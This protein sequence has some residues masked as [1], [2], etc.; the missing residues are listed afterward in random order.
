MLWLC[1]L[2][3]A[4]IAGLGGKGDLTFACHS[5]QRH[6]QV[7]NLPDCAGFMECIMIY[8]LPCASKCCVL[9]AHMLISTHAGDF[10]ATEP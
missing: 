2:D 4:P 8:I 3:Q 10:A 1:R 5:A 9:I 6:F 7:T